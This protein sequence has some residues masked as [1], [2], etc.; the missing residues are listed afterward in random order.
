MVTRR[1]NT[2]ERHRGLYGTFHTYILTIGEKRPAQTRYNSNGQN[3]PHT[4]P[5]TIAPPA[6]GPSLFGPWRPHPHPPSPKIGPPRPITHK[7]RGGADLQWGTLSLWPHQSP[8]TMVE[9]AKLRNFVQMDRRCKF[10]WISQTGDSHTGFTRPPC[11]MLV[12]MIPMQRR[13]PCVK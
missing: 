9:G 7:W 11:V 5:K 1:N 4:R 2:S 6:T 3:T 10:M 13:P 8:L 12:E